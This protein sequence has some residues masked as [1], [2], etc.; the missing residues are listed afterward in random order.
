M[1]SRAE[2]PP[3]VDEIP[4]VRVRGITR[5]NYSDGAVVEEI[6]FRASA[7]YQD[8]QNYHAEH[9]TPAQALAELG[10]FICKRQ[11]I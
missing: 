4:V 9:D 2:N 1:T 8:G 6:V 7:V 11:N 5:E 10:M 3:H